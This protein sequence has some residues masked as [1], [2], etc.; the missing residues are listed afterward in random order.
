MAHT[1]RSAAA[2]HR[3]IQ[4]I[5]KAQSGTNEPHGANYPQDHSNDQPWWTKEQ[6]KGREENRKNEVTSFHC[7]GM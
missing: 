5:Q 1:G 2:A 6:K 3:S 7:E 4:A